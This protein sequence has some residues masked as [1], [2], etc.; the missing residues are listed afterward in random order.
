MTT[1]QG[2][3][4]L[5]AQLDSVLRQ[6]RPADEIVISDDGSTDRTWELLR[7]FA[8]SSP[9]PVMLFRQQ[10][11]VGLRQ[12]VE[13]VLGACDGTVFVL[14]DQDDVWSPHKLAA[15]EAA[16]ADPSVTLW[17]S[18]AQLIDDAGTPIGTTAWAATHL[19]GAERERLAAGGGLRRLMHG[20]TVTGA[21]MAVRADVRDI[22]LPLP[23]ELDGPDHLFLHDG[24]L[25]VLAHV[26]GQTAVDPR[27]LVS[28]RQ[29]PGQVT[30]MSLA[31]GVTPTPEVGRRAERRRQ[32]LL[33]Q[34]R[35]RLVVDRLRTAGAL[36]RCR[37]DA[38][39]EL[40]SLEEFLGT[41]TLP[42]GFRGRR[43]AVLRQLVRGRY[44]RF[45]RGVRTAG[46]DLL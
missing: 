31:G 28:Y 42:R 7:E 46:R 21:T 19:S 24:W 40:L 14:S 23:P 44:H 6:T 16:F 1:Y 25:A 8:A 2:E 18:N 12:N 41:R 38:V 43:S 9:V 11:N 4:H 30:A 37:A 17:F 29:H 45:A 15:V 3:R 10:S 22:A 33:D 32:L 5:S 39:E 34:A 36:P 13:T 27:C 20:Q 35:L 26:L